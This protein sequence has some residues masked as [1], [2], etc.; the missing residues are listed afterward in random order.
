MEGY[1]QALRGGY[2]LGDQVDHEVCLQEE[3]NGD[4]RGADRVHLHVPKGG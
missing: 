3:R 2:V 1:G 4:S